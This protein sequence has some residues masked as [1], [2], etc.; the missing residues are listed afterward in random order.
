MRNRL[1]ML[2]VC[3]VLAVGAPVA[4]QD[5]EDPN[6]PG[7]WKFGAGLSLN[8]SQSSFS[9]NWT[10]GDQGSINWVLNSDLSAKRQI[11]RK[12][13]ELSNKQDAA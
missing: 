1:F 9:N 3:S 8:I 4:A 10:G 6:K 13:N 12:L 2:G 11:S 5:E 7:P